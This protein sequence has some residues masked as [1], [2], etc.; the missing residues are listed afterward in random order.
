MKASC[1]Q[2]EWYV[3]NGILPHMQMTSEHFPE[4]FYRVSVK[5]LIR[6]GNS[7]LLQHEPKPKD[8]WDMP[9]G[10]VDFGETPQEAL[11]REL[12]E[13]MGL[14][15]THVAE[16]PTYTWATRTE[17][18]RKMDWFYTLTL[19][20]QAEVEN[21]DFVSTNE[22]DE[23][24]FFTKEDIQNLTLWETNQSLKEIFNFADLS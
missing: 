20:Y 18:H 7:I 3:L 11:K 16:H 19:C 15:V 14:V 2:G 1:I 23:I 13:E 6:D 21:Y 5:A 9:G 8:W 17:N 10:G 12:M 22:C 24:G 4:C